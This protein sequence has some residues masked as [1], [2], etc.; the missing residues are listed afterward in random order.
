MSHGL[1]G[2][3]RSFPRVLYE[4]ICQAQCFVS[5]KPEYFPRLYNSHMLST[6]DARIARKVKRRLSEITNIKKMVVYGS[7]AR[8]QATK[9]SDLDLYI[10][11][12]ATSLDPALRRRIREIAW[13]V[14]L[15]SGI[16]ISTLVASDRLRGQPI[17]KAIHAE[18]IP[19]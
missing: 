8:G 16:V 10:E 15:D 17:L 9:Y 12:D 18:G 7:R 2:N 11:L 14:S 4:G 6:R 19:V 3:L 1:N 13:E 5:Q